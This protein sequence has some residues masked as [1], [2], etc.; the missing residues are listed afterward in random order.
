MDGADSSFN[1][2]WTKE[3]LSTYQW[4]WSDAEALAGYPEET[5][6]SIGEGVATAE[7]LE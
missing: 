7:Q 6:P 3:W 5:A 2:A 4:K 1:M